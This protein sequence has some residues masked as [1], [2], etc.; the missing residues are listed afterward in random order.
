MSSKLRTLGAIFLLCARIMGLLVSLS[1]TIP[2][3][4]TTE[5]VLTDFN[6][7][8]ESG[9]LSIVDPT[10]APQEISEIRVRL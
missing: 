6:M 10:G 8:G 9:Q 5:L 2:H 7:D 3:L 4:P 1:I